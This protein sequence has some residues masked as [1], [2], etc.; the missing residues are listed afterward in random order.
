ME[1]EVFLHH[2]DGHRV[3]ILVHASPIFDTDGKSIGAVQVFSDRSERSYLLTELENL[4]MEVLTDPLTGLGNRRFAE[5]SAEAAIGELE[6]GVEFGLLIL[7]IDHFKRVNDDYGHAI[8]RPGPAHDRLDPRQR[9]EAP[10]R[11]RPLGR[12]GVR[13]HL[14]PDQAG[15]ARPR[16]RSARESS[17]SAPGS[18]S[19][20][21]ARSPARSRWEGRWRAAATTWRASWREPTSA[22]TNASPADATASW[23]GTRRRAAHDRGLRSR[24][25]RPRRQLGPRLPRRGRAGLAAA[26]RGG[27]LHGRVGETRLAPRRLGPHLAASSSRSPSAPETPSS[28]TRYRRLLAD[29]RR[30]ELRVVDV[31]AAEE[32]ASLAASLAPARR[33][34]ISSADLVHVA[35]AIA[36][37]AKAIFCNDESWR[38]LPAC[39][40][41]ILVDELAAGATASLADLWPP[42][43]PW[44]EGA[45]ILRSGSRQR[46]GELGREGV[47]G[48]AGQERPLVEGIALPPPLELREQ[49]A[50]PSPYSGSQRQGWPR[51][52]RWTRTWWVR[53]VSGLRLDEATSPKAPLPR[54]LA[55]TTKLVDDR[56]PLC[57]ST[58]VRCS[59]SPSG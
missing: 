20:T 50:S 24:L 44:A 1:A 15:R 3:P 32:A 22:S 55:T 58:I 43:C 27:S 30:I 17:S 51:A 41:L 4:K 6:D 54:Y 11:R 46:M 42:A 2:K 28:P 34:W 38:E 29:S 9:G 23:S 19:T 45:S 39:P 53:P 21:D 7:D 26:T 47:Q 16:S 8:R 5:V 10:R 52:A 25:D 36:A 31:A 56:L 48:R 40:P 59:R 33:R 35:T 13:R 12:R 57:A 18:A 49:E 37:G 14:P